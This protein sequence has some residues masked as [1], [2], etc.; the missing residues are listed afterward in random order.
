MKEEWNRAAQH[1]L[2]TSILQ[3]NDGG[4]ACWLFFYSE[5]ELGEIVKKGRKN[6]YWNNTK[7][8]AF[9]YLGFLFAQL[10]WSVVIQMLAYSLADKRYFTHTHTIQY[11][12]C[13]QLWI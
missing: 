3:Q 7:Y 6:K 12:I 2:F 5:W 9:Y 1:F 11:K 13:V 8:Y 4:I 10:Y